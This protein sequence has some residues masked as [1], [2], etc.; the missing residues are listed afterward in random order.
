MMSPTAETQ[1]VVAEVIPAPTASEVQPELQAVEQVFNHAHGDGQEFS[2]TLEQ[3]RQV[4]PALGKM[5]VEAAQATLEQSDLAARVAERGRESRRTAAETKAKSAESS[6]KEK[7]DTLKTDKLKE[8][9]AEHEQNPEVTDRKSTKTDSIDRSASTPVTKVVVDAYAGGG[10]GGSSRAAAEEAE[11]L[12]RESEASKLSTKPEQAQPQPTSGTPRNKIRTEPKRPVERSRG[13]L[14][15]VRNTEEKVSAD[16][17][18]SSDATIH[19]ES[20]KS[21]IPASRPRQPRATGMEQLNDVSQTADSETPNGARLSEVEATGDSQLAW[22]EVEQL[23]LLAEQDVAARELG[24]EHEVSLF[25]TSFDPNYTADMLQPETASPR[26]PAPLGEIETALVRL[27]AALVSAERQQDQTMQ[28]IVEAIAELPGQSAGDNPEHQVNEQQL[29]DL[30]IALCEAA[31]VAHTPAL[32]TSLV[33]LTTAHYLDVLKA[34]NQPAT[35]DTP[36]ALD[37]IGTREF[38]QKLQHGLG[39]F[40]HSAAR[41]YGVGKSLLQLYAVSMSAAA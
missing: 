3:A 20:L 13:S 36:L 35:D 14:S 26:L 10:G 2:G 5:S 12:R 33:K 21:H 6:S 18:P 9:S 23:I 40:Q 7:S 22:T 34:S 37:D 25:A 27:D 16:V 19:T 24:A 17:T 31:D 32:I 38:L 15:L 39:S 28:R 1:P 41:V 29:E 4:C 30:L 11:R 8:A